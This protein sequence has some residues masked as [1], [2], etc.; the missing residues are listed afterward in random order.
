MMSTTLPEAKGRASRRRWLAL[1]GCSLLLP[2]LP[3]RARAQAAPWRFE[4]GEPLLQIR[5]GGPGQ[6]LGVGVGGGLWS[7]PLDGRPPRRLATGLDPQSLL[8]AA[9]GRIVARHADGGLWVWK[10]GQANHVPQVRLAAAAGLLN[11]P[12]AVIGVAGD[13]PPDARR[14]L[15]IEPAG[16]RG[17]AVVAR[18]AGAVLPDARPLLADLDDRGDGGHV[19]VLAGP[20]DQR[21]DHAVLGDRVEATRLL[22]LDR[23]RLQPLR[24][25]ALPMPHV[26]E[27]IAP[28]PV[29]LAHGTG[30]LTVRS[31]PSAGAQL[32]LVTA[33]P[34]HAAG[35][36]IAALGETLGAHRWLAPTTD[37][38]HWL[39]VHT[40]HIGGVLHAYTRNADRLESRVV[41][42]DLSTHRLGTRELDLAVW[43]G[44]RLVVPSQDGM[45]L[46]VLDVTAGYAE[47][48][49]ITLPARV[50]MTLALP[51]ATGV[52]ALL[53][54][55]SVV[56][57]R[58]VG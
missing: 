24:E 31:G 27:D 55:G 10:G 7:M 53:D 16:K 48:A 45:Q 56:G 23:H 29:V 5:P 34:A 49:R 21:Y 3:T 36:R 14:L 25:L 58:V 50:A 1:A 52:A 26:F 11:L 47:S 13:G 4:A 28:R 32:A 33:D 43:L 57:W 19:V 2:T 18:S 15:R 44:A 20:D 46:R 8:S 51:G 9:H 12:G 38:R 41:G 30:L 22:W 17:W 40:P 37:G 54:D 35:L 42:R 39:A 6:L